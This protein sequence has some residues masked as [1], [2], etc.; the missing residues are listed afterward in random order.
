MHYRP[1]FSDQRFMKS[2]QPATIRH[3]FGTDAVY[4]EAVESRL[5]GSRVRQAANVHSGA[6]SLPFGADTIR[7]RVG[8][9]PGL[10]EIIRLEAGRRDAHPELALAIFSLVEVT[11]Q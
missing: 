3:G 9:R 5:A 11:K 2:C 8:E 7:E 4:L 1:R 10:R 6:L